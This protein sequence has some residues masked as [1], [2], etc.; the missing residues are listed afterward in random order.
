M[1]EL[2]DF[3]L[4]QRL[5]VV[6]S[7]TADGTPQSAL[8]AVAVTRELELV[9]DTLNTSRKYVNLKRD[10]RIS[11]VLGGW[12]EGDERTVQYEGIADFPAGAELES[13]Q[14]TYFDVFPDSRYRLSWPGI[15]YVRVKPAWVRFSNFNISPPEIVELKFPLA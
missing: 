12:Q 5:A 3:I 9:F 2:T 14:R 1:Q 10:P 8:V 11:A 7:V 13:I 4:L 15:C 6:S